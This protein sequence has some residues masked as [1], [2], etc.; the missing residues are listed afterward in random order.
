[1]RGR[2]AGRNFKSGHW[3]T[4][5]SINRVLIIFLLP[6]TGKTFK[7]FP[8]PLILR[9]FLLV[10]TETCPCSELSAVSKASITQPIPGSLLFSCKDPGLRLE[11]FRMIL[12]FSEATFTLHKVWGDRSLSLRTNLAGA[13]FHRTD[14]LNFWPVI[15]PWY[16]ELRK[17]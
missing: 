5:E 6:R 13:L 3:W 11:G 8:L 10:S 9:N 15:W 7:F 4:S 12:Q 17:E 2:G 1:M 14:T 16:L